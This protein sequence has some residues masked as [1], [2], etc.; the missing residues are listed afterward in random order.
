MTRKHA[1]KPLKSMFNVF[2]GYLHSNLSFGEVNRLF[3]GR[4]FRYPHSNAF[5]FFFFFFS[6]EKCTIC[7][8]RQVL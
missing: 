2:R 1:Y 7:T 3:Y 6:V 5:F 8:K 4:K